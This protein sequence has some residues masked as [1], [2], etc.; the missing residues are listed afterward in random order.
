MRISWQRVSG[1]LSITIHR[2]S[3]DDWCMDKVQ[4][5]DNKSGFSWWV[6]WTNPD[7]SGL[8]IRSRS[9]TYNQTN[10][11]VTINM[12]VVGSSAIRL[13][14]LQL[15]SRSNIISTMGMSLVY[16]IVNFPLSPSGNFA[17]R[18]ITLPI[19]RIYHADIE[20]EDPPPPATSVS[21]RASS[22]RVRIGT[23]V[24]V[25]ASWSDA[26]D[27]TGRTYRAGA[28]LGSGTPWRTGTTIFDTASGS[29][30]RVISRINPQTLRLGF[31]AWN[32]TI[33][34][35]RYIDIEWYDDTPAPNRP[36]VLDDLDDVTV[37]VGR[38]IRVD[39]TSKLSDPDNDTVRISAT[40]SSARFSILVNPTTHVISITGSSA[41]SG[42]ITVTP[43]DQHGLSGTSK[44]FTVTVESE[45]V[46]N[47]PVI[48][49][50]PNRVVQ[51]GG[52]VNFDISSYIS[53]PDNDAVSIAAT[54]SNTRVSLTV[55]STAHTFSIRGVSVGTTTI[56]VT[57]TDEHNLRGTAKTFRVTVTST[58]PPNQPPVLQQPSEITVT[59]GRQITVDYTSLLSDP[60]NDSITIAATESS[61]RFSISVDASRHRITVTGISPGSGTMQVTPTDEHGLSG[62]TRD[63]SV[64][65]L[66]AAS[67]QISASPTSLRVRRNATISASWAGSVDDIG[68][69]ANVTIWDSNG[70]ILHTSENS[71]GNWTGTVSRNSAGSVTYFINCNG[72]GTVES[73]AD[74]QVRITWSRRSVDPPGPYDSI[75]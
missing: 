8:T 63:V 31:S 57:P 6:G 69:Y 2:E 75:V 23:D 59:E 26:V 24:T 42:D 52:T 45:E 48:A 1:V 17:S 44:S 32:G 30:S 65:V 29:F 53:D 35:A 60:D 64:K 71:S 58:P 46:N 67:C 7:L 74:G 51:V 34:V 13:S 70:T 20:C 14:R 5:F 40:E 22:T 11:T 9:A 39:L 27:H 55:N 33:W 4:E 56:T 41:G 10:E 61:A 36:P 73:P 62:T 50:L 38:T 54:R 49:D 25:T 28:L 37:R 72:G 19:S 3:T 68:L 18:N 16:Q 21:I 15:R 66:E 47:P 43:T 12:G